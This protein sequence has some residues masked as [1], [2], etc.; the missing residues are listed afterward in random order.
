MQQASYRFEV[1]VY[2]ANTYSIFLALQSIEEEIELRIT[3][4][5]RVNAS[6]ESSL[7]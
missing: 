3:L 5:L 1:N 4:S 2:E 7:R 6:S